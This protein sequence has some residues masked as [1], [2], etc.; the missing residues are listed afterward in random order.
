[1]ADAESDVQL[2]VLLK[3]HAIHESQG[4]QLRLRR[5]PGSVARLLEMTG[6]HE[7]LEAE[8]SGCRDGRSPRAFETD[9]LQ[10]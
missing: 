3:A 6:T 8:I 7:I 9:G 4:G 5:L 1:M 10:L 2:L